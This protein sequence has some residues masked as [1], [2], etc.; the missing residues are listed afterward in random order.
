M[1]AKQHPTTPVALLLCVPF[2]RDRLKGISQLSESLI[3]RT[4]NG[5]AQVRNGRG[6][7]RRRG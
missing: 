1:I 7:L 5:N 3:L 2:E 4:E 6:S